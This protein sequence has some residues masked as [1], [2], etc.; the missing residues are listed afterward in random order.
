MEI[1][2]NITAENKEFIE[3]FLDGIFEPDYCYRAVQHFDG[4]NTWTVIQRVSWWDLF[5]YDSEIDPPLT[6]ENIKT[7]ESRRI[8][9]V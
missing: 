3:E 5:H 9:I 8:V 7:V 6:W 4:V 1:T 2:M